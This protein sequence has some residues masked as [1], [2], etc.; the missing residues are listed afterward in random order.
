MLHKRKFNSRHEVTFGS[1]HIAWL[2]LHNRV[3]LP[4]VSSVR[5]PH[6]HGID[7][8]LPRPDVGHTAVK[9]PSEYSIVVLSIKQNSVNVGKT[10]TVHA[11]IADAITECKFVSGAYIQGE[12]A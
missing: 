3:A 10:K 7:A 6:G 9:F 12:G 8:T 5:L 1:A 2:S 11:A 4:T